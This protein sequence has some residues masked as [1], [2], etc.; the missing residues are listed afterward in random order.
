MKQNIAHIYKL[1]YTLRRCVNANVIAPNAINANVTAPNAINATVPV[2][3]RTTNPNASARAQN[4]IA[5]VRVRTAIVKNAM[6][7]ENVSVG[8]SLFF[9]SYVSKT[10]H[11]YGTEARRNRCCNKK[12]RPEQE[13]FSDLERERRRGRG[14]CHVPTPGDRE[15]AHVR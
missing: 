1:I 3:V 6:A 10:S 2:M 9:P 7:T 14:L 5:V 13:D 4:A 12:R 8:R 11:V 15:I